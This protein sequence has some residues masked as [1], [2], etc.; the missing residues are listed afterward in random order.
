MLFLYSMQKFILIINI[1]IQIFNKENNE[2]PLIM[3]HIN[4]ILDMI[5]MIKNTQTTLAFT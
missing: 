2:E 5:M 4:T 3:I 1:I